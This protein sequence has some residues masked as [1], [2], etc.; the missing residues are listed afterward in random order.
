[1]HQDW[2]K[3]V[4]LKM[5]HPSPAQAT[6]APHQHLRWLDGTTWQESKKEKH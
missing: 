6:V 3:K 4:E 2:K 1:M 5:I